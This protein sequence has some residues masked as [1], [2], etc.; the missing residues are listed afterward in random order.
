MKTPVITAVLIIF[1]LVG[2]SQNIELG[3]YKVCYEIYG[4]CLFQNIVELKADSTFEFSYLDDY[5][6]RKADGKWE[7]ESNYLY[8]ITLPVSDT[9]QVSDIFETAGNKS[10]K[11]CI[12][13]NFDNNENIKINIFQKGVK[14]EYVTNS[15][16]EL[17]YSGSV[18]DSLS[19]ELGNKTF[20]VIPNRKEKPSS[21]TIT[22]DS[23][24]KGLVYQQ[25]KGNKIL[26]EDGKM[27]I[28]YRD[29]ENGDIKTGYFE[30]I[31]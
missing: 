11:I 5:Q 17:S 9:F 14:K 20:I 22:V 1:S 12:Y 26:I 4:K 25:L 27:T 30:R 24:Y 16:G 2:Y 3:K 21:I 8:L 29:W 28:R 7:I 19:F 23:N 31:N 18:A 10:N 13:E 15:F 6:T